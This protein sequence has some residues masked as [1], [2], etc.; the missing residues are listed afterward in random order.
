MNVPLLTLLA[1]TVGVGSGLSSRV[2]DDNGCDKGLD[3]DNAL[4][5]E[6]V[7]LYPDG[8]KR[9][10]G[11]YSHGKKLGVHKAWREN[12]KPERVDRYVAGRREGLSEEFDRDGNLKSTCEYRAD[13]RNGLC[14]EY[15]REGKLREERTWVDG[16]EQGEAVKF[17]S[18]GEPV[19]SRPDVDSQTKRLLP[20]GGID[21][22]GQAGKRTGDEV[23]FF[24]DGGTQSS[25]ALVAGKREGMEREWYRSGKLK[26]ELPWRAD[27]RDGIERE[28]FESGALRT[29]VHWKE[30]VR[31]GLLRDFH[32]N[33]QLRQQSCLQ[34][35]RLVTGLA[36]CL[37]TSG[38][39]VLTRYFPDGKPEQVEPMREGKRHGDFKRYRPRGGLEE[40]SRWV[41]GALD[42]VQ[43]LYG[44]NG[45]LSRTTTWKAG[46]REGPDTALFEDGG[47]SEQALWADDSR[48]ALAAWWMNG[49]KKRE[50]V[51]E[52]GLTVLRTWHDTGKQATE[53]HLK[54]S[55]KQGVERKWTEAGVLTNDYL[56]LDGKPDGVEK[57]FDPKTGRLVEEELWV[58]GVRVSRRTFDKDSGAL[59]TSEQFYP[60]GSRK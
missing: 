52:G 38:P 51:D 7:C 29:E 12:G 8:S 30:G 60:D 15:G 21:S 39:E 53:V 13:R 6:M 58:K 56:W 48:R 31:D 27:R 14:R 44:E 54:G 46:R 5:G 26:H 4:D 55:T 17:D 50:E 18:R 32:E 10:E 37:G 22:S 16:E 3:E 47:T 24:A 42:G 11:T 28:Y 45:A 40:E 1:L 9:S 33:G 36:P 25:R 43:K 34:S 59:L 19:R 20:D 35:G 57:D 23:R 41:D 49:K 2:T